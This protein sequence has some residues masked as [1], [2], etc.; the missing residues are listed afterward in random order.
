MSI[1]SAKAIGSGSLLNPKREK[2][3]RRFDLRGPAPAASAATSS[4]PPYETASSGNLCFHASSSKFLLSTSLQS[5][6]NAP[7]KLVS[8]VPSYKPPLE[9]FGTPSHSTRRTT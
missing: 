1:C 4:A 2:N 8:S 5:F 7:R 6:R 9:Y 3:V